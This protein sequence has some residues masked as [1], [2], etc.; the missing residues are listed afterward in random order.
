MEPE[1]AAGK[2][3]SKGRDSRKCAAGRAKPILPKPGNSSFK[4]MKQG[5]L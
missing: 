1:V 5:F 4:G 3:T 2:E